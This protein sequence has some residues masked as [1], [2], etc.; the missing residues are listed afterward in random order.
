MATAGQVTTLAALTADTFDMVVIGGGITGVSV[1][2]EASANG[3]SVLVVDKSDFGSGTSSATTKFIHGGIRYL[4]TM[5]VGVVRESLRERRILALAAPHLVRQQRFLM[6]AWSWSRPNAPVIGLGVGLYGGLAYDRN[7]DVPDSLRIPRSAWLSRAT[8]LADVPWLQGEELKGAWAYYD[9]L[10][11]FPERLLLEFLFT[12]VGQGAVAV[13]Y[14][15]A[16][17]LVFETDDDGER[18]VAG[19]RVVDVITG[20]QRAVTAPIVINAA[21]PWVDEVLTGLDSGVHVL[22]SKG[23][24]VLLSSIDGL[25]QRDAVFARAKSGGHVIVSPWMGRLLV[26]PTDTPVDE[27]VDETHALHSDVDLVLSTLNETLADGLAPVQS[28][29]VIDTTVGVR[30]LIGTGG[31][32]TYNASR[33][34][35]VHD[36]ASEGYSGLFSILGGKWTTGRATAEHLLRVL[37][38]SGHW[39]G[40]HLVSTRQ[41]AV[42]SSFAWADDPKPYLTDLVIAWSTLG[43]DRGVIDSLA[44]LYGSKATELLGL[45]AADPS[46]GARISQR[47]GIWDIGAQVVWGVRQEGARE[48]SDLIDRRMTIGSMGGITDEEIRTIADLAAPLMGA[49]PQAMAAAETARRRGLRALWS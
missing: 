44:M 46:L 29:D 27:S 17:E 39:P 19:V 35:E 1:A 12:A 47:E 6:P 20:E 3:M 42:S 8:V 22:R 33:R 21:G 15:R 49:D 26:G 14:A 2:R 43:L 36:H 40:H 41:S 28:A 37:A 34:H 7:R 45:V 23:V 24:H 13:N 31:E 48:L 5:E 18:H 30:P 25:R 10:N 16:T 11:L 38:S 4:E 32:G 9:T